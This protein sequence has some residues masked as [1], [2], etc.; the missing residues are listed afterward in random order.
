LT[1]FHEDN[2]TKKSAANIINAN[3]QETIDS[4]KADTGF[5]YTEFLLVFTIKALDPKNEF[6][7]VII[8]K[9]YYSSIA[10]K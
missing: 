10:E 9:N 4:P 5:L 7:E 6:T 8:E 2:I 3:E 1:L